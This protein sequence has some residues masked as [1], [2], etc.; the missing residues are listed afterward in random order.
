METNDA[1]MKI[2]LKKFLLFF[3]FLLFSYVI[4]LCIFSIRLFNNKIPNI[5]NLTNNFF[6]RGA[7]SL[8]TTKNIDILFVG[9]SRCNHSFDPRVFDSSGV[10][11]ANLS[12]YSLRPFN[13]YYMIKNRQKD[14]S[15][16]YVV[17]ETS[18][19]LFNEHNINEAAQVIISNEKFSKILFE[20]ALRTKDY[21]TIN[22]TIALYFYRMFHPLKDEKTYQQANDP[23]GFTASPTDK[24]AGKEADAAGL[25]EELVSHEAF[26]YMQKSIDLV[27]QNNSTVIFIQPPVVMEYRTKATNYHK[28]CYSI[29]SLAKLN[30]IPYINY[31]DSTNYMRIGLDVNK[32]FNDVNHLSGSGADKFSKVVLADMRRLGI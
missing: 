6:L 5:S 9:S 25:R 27:K 14:I 29:D 18:F 11:T 7:R 21:E 19:D 22:S 32:D 1:V 26:E 10:I 8:D 30:N 15:N 2:F 13:I 4:F 3:S 17:L 23:P 20:M 28:L 24:N 31:N 12:A 16:K